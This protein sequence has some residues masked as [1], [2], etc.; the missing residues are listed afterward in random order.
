MFAG[1]RARSSTA[2]GNHHGGASEARDWLRQAECTHLAIEATGVYSKPV[3]HMLEGEFQLLFANPAHIRN[4]PGHKS[5]INDATWDSRSFG[6]R[7][8]SREPGA[9]GPIQELRDL[10]RTRKQLMRE[11]TQHKQRI[12]KSSGSAPGVLLNGGV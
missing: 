11:I 7:A 4:V 9:A 2:L 5:D 1:A 8:D 10:T 6:A 3:W 12:Q